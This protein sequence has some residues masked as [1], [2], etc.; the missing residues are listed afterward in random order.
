MEE[1]V[2][3][4]VLF[5]WNLYLIAHG[6]KTILVIVF[7]G[8]VFEEF[9][10]LICPNGYDDLYFLGIHLYLIIDYTWFSVLSTN[11]NKSLLHF[12]F[13]YSFEKEK[14]CC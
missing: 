6:A 13:F 3:S 8:V 1:V 9:T 14:I 4:F 11:I 5:F 10:A 2:I 12:T 7:F